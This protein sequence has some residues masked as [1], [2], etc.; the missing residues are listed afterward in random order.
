M[1]VTALAR[2][3]NGNLFAGTKG[4]GVLVSSNQGQTF[5]Q[6]GTGQD[7]ADVIDIVLDEGRG[8]YY[9]ATTNGVYCLTRE[10]SNGAEAALS[11]CH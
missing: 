2:D 6:F 4:N 11:S 10:T 5:A 9:M 1:T 8:A 7:E 3:S